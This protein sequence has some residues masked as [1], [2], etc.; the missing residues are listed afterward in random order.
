MGAMRAYQLNATAVSASKQMI[1][2][3]L[4]LLR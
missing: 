4:S 1:Q 2:E 3:A